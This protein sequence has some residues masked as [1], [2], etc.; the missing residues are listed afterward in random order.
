MLGEI[1]K[2]KRKGLGLTQL[3][4]AEQLNISILKLATWEAD[5]DI[6]TDEQFILLSKALEC[7]ITELT[8]KKIEV[9]EPKVVEETPVEE[10]T[11]VVEEAP[12]EQTP[13]VEEPKATP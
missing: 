1:I 5:E 4:L 7:P 3:D 9:E 2:Q 12:V 10:E 8:D 6:P 11:K 13:V